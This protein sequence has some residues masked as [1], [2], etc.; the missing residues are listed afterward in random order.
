[1]GNATVFPSFF[2]VITTHTVDGFRNPAPVDRYIVYPIIYKVLYIPGGAGFIP[3]GLKPSFFH[4]FFWG[5]GPT[6]GSFSKSFLNRRKPLHS[7]CLLGW[8]GC[9]QK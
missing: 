2:G 5:G 3:C 7:I 8:Y 4:A 9:F 1:M 6:V